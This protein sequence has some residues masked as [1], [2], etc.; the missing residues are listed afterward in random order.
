MRFS[1]LS[2][3]ME[4]LKRSDDNKRRNQTIKGNVTAQLENQKLKFPEKPVQSGLV[5]RRLCLH[6]YF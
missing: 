1:H 4:P 5:N 6:Y 3:Q 2:T